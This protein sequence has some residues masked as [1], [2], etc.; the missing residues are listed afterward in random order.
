MCLVHNTPPPLLHIAWLWLPHVPCRQVSLLD[1]RT[2]CGLL[3][4]AMVPYWFAAM[5]MKSV[6]AAAIAMV[7]EI[8]HH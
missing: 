8:Q 2:F 7:H 4:R 3:V 5:T 6:G 1:P